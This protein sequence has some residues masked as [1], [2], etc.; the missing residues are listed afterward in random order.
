MRVLVPLAALALT[1]SCANP[2]ISD[3]TFAG[4]E[5]ECSAT[6]T[7]ADGACGGHAYVITCTFNADN[8]IYDCTCT[9]DGTAGQTFSEAGVCEQDADGAFTDFDL[10]DAADHGVDDC[11]FPLVAPEGDEHE[12]EDE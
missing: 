9:T 7:C 4:D 8:D 5:T 10:A 2:T 6:F 1:A 11:Q 12:H 3:A